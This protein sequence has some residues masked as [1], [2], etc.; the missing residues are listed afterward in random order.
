M[1]PRYNLPIVTRILV[2]TLLFLYFLS[3]AYQYKSKGAGFLPLYGDPSLVPQIVVIPNFTISYPWTV[4]TATYVEANIATLSV[5]GLA[6]FF[7]GRYLERAWSSSQ[8]ATLMLLIA[9]VPNI[10]CTFLYSI[11]LGMGM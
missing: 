8:L 4:L 2:L 6:L 3:A 1:A 7:G 5:S 10:A 11:L 9:L